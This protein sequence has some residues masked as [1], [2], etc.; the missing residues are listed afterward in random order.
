[1]PQVFGL[2][3]KDLKSRDLLSNLKARLADVDHH[4]EHAKREN[5]EAR[6]NTDGQCGPGFGSCAA[7]YCC[8]GS[9]GTGTGCMS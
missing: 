8:S 7:G 2:N 1:M 9:S 6:Q 5:L 4:K 3:I